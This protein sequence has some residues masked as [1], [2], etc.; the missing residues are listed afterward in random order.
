[1]Q[2]VRAKIRCRADSGIFLDGSQ[3]KP[4][5]GF[6]FQFGQQ[7]G[8]FARLRVE[9]LSGKLRIGQ[10]RFKLGF[11]L[12]EAGNLGLQG[13]EFALLGIG[14]LALSAPCFFRRCRRGRGG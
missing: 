14:A 5:L 2:V 4:P 3:F 9:G 10:G 12:F 8:E 7:A 13:I 6:L 11:A 1:M